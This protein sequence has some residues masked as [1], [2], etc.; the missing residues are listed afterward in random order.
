MSSSQDTLIGAYTPH[1]SPRVRAISRKL[2]LRKVET[3][4]LHMEDNIISEGTCKW[5][6]KMHIE[7]IEHA[8]LGSNIHTITVGKR[9]I[10]VGRRDRKKA[11]I[12]VTNLTKPYLKPMTF[13]K[14][15]YFVKP[16]YTINADYSFHLMFEN[17]EASQPY[18]PHLAQ[19]Y[20]PHLTDFYHQ[21][22][23]FSESCSL[24][25]FWPVIV[26]NQLETGKVNN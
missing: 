22:S 19:S 23:S 14:Y 16:S 15:R 26:S 12:M 8:I 5:E 21:T 7:K 9:A 3:W 2:S 11:S 10:P 6:F 18:Y 24:P 1:E 4:I 13:F 17:M 25:C 20:Y